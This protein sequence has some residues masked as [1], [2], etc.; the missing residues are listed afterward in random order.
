MKI[1]LKNRLNLLIRQRGIYS[2]SEFGRRMTAAGFPLSSSHASRYEKED[3]PP[4]DHKF[5]KVACNV[6]QCTPNEFYDIRVEL[7]EKETIDPLIIL[8]RHADVVRSEPTEVQAVTTSIQNKPSDSS[9]V[10]SKPVI[11]TPTKSAQLEVKVVP[12]SAP[13]K[14]PTIDDTGPSGIIFPFIK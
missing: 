4:F 11:S 13:R 1:F 10:A 7:E 14:L 3:S 9:S 6:L 12:K 2:A 5:L 8:P